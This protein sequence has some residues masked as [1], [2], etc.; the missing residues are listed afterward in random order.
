[1]IVKLRGY[2]ARTETA[3]TC[4]ERRGILKAA[5]GAAGV[6][7]APAALAAIPRREG[8]S[9][10]FYNTHTSERLKATYWEHGHY[11]PDALSEI[12]HLLRDHRSGEVHVI[13]PS[14]LDLL[15]LL[16]GRLE[17]HKPFHVISGYRS[18]ATNSMLR[19]T[20][21]G[22]VAKRSLHMQGMA[23]DIRMPGVRLADLRKAAVQARAGGVGYYPS[24]SF[25]HVDVGRVRYW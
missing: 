3:H 12:N 20:G 14:L 6:L 23:I 4:P 19:K 9:L 7:A 10:A 1:M 25:V 18:P 17:T 22:G 21:G 2:W 24:S 15:D 11:L 13:D 5:V 8:R 16:Q